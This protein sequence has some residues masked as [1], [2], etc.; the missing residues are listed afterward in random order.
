[1][2][3]HL[4]LSFD[5][6]EIDRLRSVLGLLVGLDAAERA[7]PE[8][9]EQLR[10]PESLQVAKARAVKAGRPTTKAALPAAPA[11][12]PD[13]EPV[14]PPDDSDED[15]GLEDPSMSPG[16]AREAALAL[17]REAYTSGHVAAVKALQKEL[18][19]AKFYDVPV[20]NGNAFYARVMKLAHETGIRR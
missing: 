10:P 9:P 18:Q 19:V 4:N 11:A 5:P 13:E 12:V 16:E 20:A 3:V 6:T 7:E 1:M 2:Q 8:P 14:S 15:I 17:V